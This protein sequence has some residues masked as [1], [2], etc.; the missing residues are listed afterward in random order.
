MTFGRLLLIVPPQSCVLDGFRTALI[1]LAAYV[2]RKLPAIEVAILD[3]SVTHPDAIAPELRARLGNGSVRTLVGISTVTADYQAALGVAQMIK[4]IDIS[5]VVVFGGHHASADARTILRAHPQKV[6]FVI[7]GEGEIPLASLLSEYPQKER[8]PGLAF[9][10]RST[11]EVQTNEAAPFLGEAEL[12]QIPVSLPGISIASQPGK[13]EHATYVSARGCPLKCAFCAVASQVIRHKSIAQVIKDI[14]ELVQLG[15]RRIAFEDN[16]F[17]NK[18]TRTHALCRELIGL[19]REGLDF[20]WDCQT[21]VES[22]LDPETIAL[23]EAAG[24]EAI[25]LGAESLVGEDL[26]F[27]EKVKN[28][29]RYLTQLTDVVVPALLDSKIRCYINLQFGLPQTKA[30]TIAETM[31]VMTRLGELAAGRGKEIEVFP[32]LF[33][34]YPGTKHFDYFRQSRVFR[35]EDVFEGFTKW[36]AD[37]K[38]VLRW[39]GETFAHGTGGIPLGI[40]DRGLLAR[41]EFVVDYRAVEAVTTLINRIDGLDGVKVFRYGQYLVKDDTHEHSIPS[42]ADRAS[43]IRLVSGGARA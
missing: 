24:C 37:Q 7:V 11:G 19:R 20:V 4:E 30:S 32:Q 3:L 5:T 42:D 16:F 6:D 21:R 29:N 33:V 17:A 27:L 14:R 10:S 23:M 36:E 28:T 2:R 40:M 13:F 8:V 35:D 39:L 43:R 41:G 15:H 18:K 9:L 26:G 38:P 34:V 22:L 1:A 25:Y 31:A 12:D